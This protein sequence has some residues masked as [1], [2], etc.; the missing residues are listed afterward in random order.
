MSICHLCEAH[1]EMSLEEAIQ[2]LKNC[3]VCKKDVETKGSLTGLG[4]L[5]F[6]C[7]QKKHGRE[8]VLEQWIFQKEIVD[9][10]LFFHFKKFMQFAGLKWKN[11]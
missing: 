10:C 3:K 4:Y 2:K 11:T 1:L 5:L 8:A 6:K 9:K 7:L